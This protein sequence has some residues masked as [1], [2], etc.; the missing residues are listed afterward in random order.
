MNRKTEKSNILFILKYSGHHKYKILFSAVF[1][2]ISSIL[3][4]SLYLLL[5]YILVELTSLNPNKML[6]EKVVKYTMVAVVLSVLFQI[7]CLAMSHLAAFSILY[8][9]RKKVVKHLGKINLGFFRKNSIGQI[10]KAVDE[11]I[12]KLELFIAHQ[13]PDLIEAIVVPLVIIIYLFTINWLLALAL[14]IPFFISFYIQASMFKG[15]GQRIELYN[16]M[17]KKLHATIVQYI[18]AMNI[19]KAFN[20]TAKNFKVYKNTVNEYLKI[21]KEMCDL[22]IGKYSFGSAI[23]DAGGLLICISIGGL[24][25]LKGA[26]D[27]ASLV[28]FLLL[29]TVFLISFMKIMNLGTNLAVLLVGAENVRK[30]LEHN[31]QKDKDIELKEIEEG[32]IEFKNVTFRYDKIEVL[33]DFNLKFKAKKMTALVGPSGSGKTTIGMLIGRFWDVEEGEILIDGI[34]VKDKSLESI[35]KNIAF[36][37]QDS[38]ILNDTVYKNIAMGMNVTKEEVIE[39]CKKAQIHDFIMQMKMGYETPLGEDS[40]IKL[41]GGEKQRISIA[42]AILKN[43]KIIV[44]DEITSYSDVENEK[45][46]QTSIDNLLRDKTS[47]II[48]HRLYTIKN[49]DNI[50]VL[51]N[52]KIIEEGSHKKLLEKDGLYKKLWSISLE[53]GQYV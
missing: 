36:V 15:Y 50:V 35:M 5:Y 38:F 31:M 43:A 16:K 6:I 24:L 41:S 17:L 28:M 29:G 22:T 33:K 49:A 26:L 20:L 39:A 4:L 13:I 44:L 7:L 12:E 27:F 37:F 53:G 19:L 10:K 47:I 21:W 40:G 42:R 25:Y 34:N 45:L 1:S 32:E 8:E 46:I 2:S 3:R 23:I 48:A 14:F 18:N 30:I 11:D 51:D 52:G 9:I